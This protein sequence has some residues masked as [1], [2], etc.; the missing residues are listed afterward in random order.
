MLAEGILVRFGGNAGK[1][2]QSMA[3]GYYADYL[4]EPETCGMNSTT[5]QLVRSLSGFTNPERADAQV[6]FAGG[7]SSFEYHFPMMAAAEGATGI[8]ISAEVCS[9][10]P[11]CKIDY[12]SDIS[13]WVEN[14]LVGVF[15]SPGDM[16]HRRGRF[17]PSWV[18]LN[19]TQYG[20]LVKWR[21][22]MKGCWVNDKKIAVHPNYKDLKLS[23]LN[24]I[25]VRIG[26]DKKAKHKGGV[27]IFGKYFGDFDQDI[28]L[29]W[30]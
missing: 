19:W 29:K 13:L 5:K 18:P 9:E 10:Y 6:I 2:E 23:E 21:I 7:A 20:F 25:R 1:R 28:V 27:N 22:D 11:N 8:E 4:V 17:T 3:V 15:H 30:I 24:E 16:G 26:V 12:R 14:S